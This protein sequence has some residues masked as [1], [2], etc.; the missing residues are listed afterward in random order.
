MAD[1][2]EQVKNRVI[3]L[4]LIKNV[5][6]YRGADHCYFKGTRGRIKGFRDLPQTWHSRSDISQLEE[7]VRWNECKRASQGTGA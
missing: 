6:I 3:N 4:T 2:F 5:K 7:E 1:F